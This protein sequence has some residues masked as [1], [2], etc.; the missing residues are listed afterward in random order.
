[1]ADASFNVRLLS[2][3]PF[4]TMLDRFAVAP[5]LIPIARDFHA[6]LQQVALIATAYYFVYALAQPVWGF[7]SDRAGRIRIIRLSLGAVAAG[8]TLSALAPNLAFLFVARIVAGVAVCAVVPTAL[9]YVAD[10]VPFQRRQSVIADLLAAVAVGTAVGTLAAGVFAHFWTWRL[11][12]ALPAVVAAVLT[13][14][15]RGFPESTMAEAATSPVTQLRRALSRPWARFL[16]LF[17]IPEGAMILGFL[18]YLAPAL[19]STGQNPAVAGL[20]VAVYGAAVLLGTQIVKR[21]ASR[22]PGWVPILIG[23]VMVIAGYL[24]AALGQ[25]VPEILFAG[26]MLGGCY[27]FLHSG[28]QSWATDVAP[29]ARGTSTALFVTGAFTGAAIGSGVGAGFAQARD[30]HGLFLAAA[31]V[32]LPVVLIAVFARARYAGSSGL[33]SAAT[34]AS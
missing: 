31:A 34:A 32:S 27:A 16:V 33:G 18:V 8:C 30:Y 26:A 3:G 21:V 22:V 7:L 20:V 4:V 28:L 19:E 9:V 2:V 17:A 5:I 6:P 12:F 11:A 13:V 14:A 1:V 25:Q 29:E 24:V 23:G 15:L 10:M